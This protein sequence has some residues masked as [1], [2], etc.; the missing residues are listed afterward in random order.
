MSDRKLINY[1]CWVGGHQVWT[2]D[3]R[4]AMRIFK[5]LRTRQDYIEVMDF[6]PDYGRKALQPYR[7]DMCNRRKLSF[8]RARYWP[9]YLKSEWRMHAYNRQTMRNTQKYCYTDERT[10][11]YVRLT[12]IQPR[13]YNKALEKRRCARINAW[14]DHTFKQ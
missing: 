12:R 9:E 5:R 8:A 6:R 2:W 3:R 11:K 7:R 4:T 10:W 14:Y 13:V 1:E